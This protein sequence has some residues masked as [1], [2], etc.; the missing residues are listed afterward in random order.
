MFGE[1]G[2]R[3]SINVQTS[4]VAP[5]HLSPDQGMI[6]AALGN[7]LGDDVLRKA[8]ATPDM[9]RALRPVLGV[10]E[11]AVFPRGCTITATSRS[12]TVSGT[13]GDDV[14]CALG[15]DD[16]VNG[17]GGVDVVYGDA[18][19]DRIAAGAGDDTVYGDEGDDVCTGDAD[20]DAPGGC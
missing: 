17:G 5:S 10:E 2:F 16:V 20:D 1:W 8:F 15:G 11:F 12:E 3:D 18:G 9:R 4:F 7:E 14:I 6:M 19:N 13:S